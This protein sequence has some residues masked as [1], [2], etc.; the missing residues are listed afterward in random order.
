MKTVG[1]LC[2][3]IFL[4]I[5]FATTIEAQAAKCTPAQLEACKKVCTKDQLAKC[6]KGEKVRCVASSACTKSATHSTSVV[7]NA[8]MED[9]KPASCAQKSETAAIETKENLA[10]VK[11]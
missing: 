2:I 9:A 4:S 8:K 1:T 6:A 5:C 11:K 3:A 7:S 10:A